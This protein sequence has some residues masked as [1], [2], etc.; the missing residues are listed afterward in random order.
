MQVS[1]RVAE[2]R[3]RAVVNFVDGQSTQLQQISANSTKFQK[4]QKMAIENKV[5]KNEW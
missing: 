4:R 2:A 3:K 1:V 5:L